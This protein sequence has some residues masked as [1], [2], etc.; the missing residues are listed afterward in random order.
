MIQVIIPN[1]YVER[2]LWGKT[3]TFV[4]NQGHLLCTR[5]HLVLKKPLFLRYKVKPCTKLRGAGK[6]LRCFGWGQITG[7]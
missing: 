5:L 6:G 1:G 7:G 3:G 4:P 2:H